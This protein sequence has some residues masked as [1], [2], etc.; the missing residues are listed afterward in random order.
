MEIEIWK[1]IPGYEGL[2]QAS[3]LGRIKGLPKK[4]RCNTG[5]TT[6]KEC[7][8]K[9]TFKTGG[10]P[11]VV[12]Y[13]DSRSKRSITVHRLIATTFLPN[14]ENKDT[15]NHKN[16]IKTN[17]KVENLEWLT[18]K[19]NINHAYRTGIAKGRQGEKHGR[20]KLTTDTVQ[21]IRSVYKSG[22]YN[23]YELASMHNVNPTT[24]QR[25]V[26]GKHWKE[27]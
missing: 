13:K 7:I 1:D 25:I 21:T 5:H 11:F 20:S 26:S 2:Y 17:N 22:I 23:T 18:K 24:I 9:P 4:V 10:Y 6:T 14:P 16:G 19:E 15:V 8:L 12:L 3:S 27:I